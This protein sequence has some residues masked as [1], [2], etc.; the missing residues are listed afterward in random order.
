[1]QTDSFALSNVIPVLIDLSVSTNVTNLSRSLLQSLKTR[2][3]ILLN[4]SNEHFDPIPSAACLLDPLVD[5]ILMTPETA[6]LLTAAKQF[7][8]STCDFAIES[9][10]ISAK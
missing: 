10:F 8:V 9:V 6:E 4:P 3:D 2:F 7:I 1:M 5:T